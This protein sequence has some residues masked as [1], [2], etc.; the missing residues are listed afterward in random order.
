MRR[1]TWTPVAVFALLTPLQLQAADAG[2][3]VKDETCLECHGDADIEPTTT[4]V[5]AGLHVTQRSLLGS[6]HEDVGCTDCHTPTGEERAAHYEEGGQ[7]PALSCA[8]CHEVENTQYEK[9]CIHG[10]EHLKGNPRAP[11]C[12]DCHG[13]HQ[14][15]PLSSPSSALAPKNQPKLCGKCHGG[16]EM[17]E[18]HVSK[19]R[20]VDRYYTSVHWQSVQEGKPAATCS[21]CH[22][23]HDVLPSSDEGSHMTRVGLM[24]TCK[25]CHAAVTHTYAEGAHG[26]TLLRGNHDVPTCTTCHG[27]H[28][29]ISLKTQAGG[30]REYAATQVCIWCHGNERMMARYALDTSPVESYMRDFHGLTQRGSLGT[31]ATCADCHD[32]HHSLPSTHPESRMHLSNRG[33]TCKKCHGQSS[34]SFIMSFSHKT[35]GRDTQGSRVKRIITWVYVAL[36]LAVVGGMLAHNAVIWFYFVTRKK[37]YQLRKG[38]VTRLTAGERRWHWLLLTSFGLLVV[39]GFALS[40]SE[41]WLFSWLYGL[42]VTEHMR[43]WLHRIGGVLLTLDMAILA[44]FALGRSGRRKWWIAMWP[45]WVDFKDFWNTMR[46]YLFRSDRLPRYAVFNYAEKAEYWALWWGTVVMALTGVAMWFSGLL[47][48]SWPPWVFDAARTIHYYEAIL[49]TLAIG[50]WHGFHV[51]FHPAEY[52]LDTSWLTGRL[53][54]DEAHERFTA[55]AIATQT[56]APDPDEV[57]P[58]PPEKKEWLHDEER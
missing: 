15:L 24:T 20:L 46:Y 58:V 47:P 38:R 36:I 29:M 23:K 3:G 27:D 32:P 49:A 44:L 53:T 50:V 35:I 57:Q 7:T 21:D 43:G 12:S 34:E 19:R 51:M 33:A 9:E 2:G 52:P 16:D 41:S 30:T 4:R 26:R 37:R 42:G 6:A 54:E 22:G 25:K 28:D 11:W 13:G 1:A 14:I 18:D 55:E 45:G 48:A 56:L 8:A 5:A 40:F 17:I 10:R 39:T 31:S